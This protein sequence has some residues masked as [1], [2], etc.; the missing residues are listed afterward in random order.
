M[1]NKY[2]DLNLSCDFILRLRN[3]L[4]DITKGKR[5]KQEIIEMSP[6]EIIHEILQDFLIIH[7]DL[8]GMAERDKEES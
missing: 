8:Y 7:E 5:R 6:S 4:V 1:K 2:I 3:C